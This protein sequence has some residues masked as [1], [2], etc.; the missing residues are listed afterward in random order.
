MKVRRVDFTLLQLALDRRY[1]D[2]NGLKSQRAIIL[3]RVETDD[4]ATGWG[5]IANTRN[6]INVLH[7]REARD[8]L[9]GKD[10]RASAPLVRKLEVL[11]PRIAGGIDGALADLRGQAA[12]LSLAMLLGGSFRAAQP[13]YASLQN[14]SE[15]EDVVADAVAQA[16]AALALGF[17]H[18]KMKVAWHRPEQDAAWINAVLRSLPESVTLAIDAN[19]RLDIASAQRLVGLIDRPDR[20]AWFEEPC[21]N[22]FPQMY[23]DLRERLAMPIAGGES[24]P[25]TVLNRV[26][27]RRMMDIVQPDLITHG[28]LQPMLNLSALSEAFGVKL[29]PHCFDGQLVRMATLHVLAS[30]PDWEERPRT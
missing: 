15:A 19:R 16:E 10:A 22:R 21:S 24:M 26:I 3:V 8:A 11:G 27:A 29:I 2:A 23:Q 6:D 7:L 30:R 28:G 17:R 20:I 5:E 12:G 1:G 18:I 14:A 25:V 4:G 9:L 13:C